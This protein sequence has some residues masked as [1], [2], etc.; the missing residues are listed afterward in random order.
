MCWRNQCFVLTAWQTFTDSEFSLHCL[1]GG[2]FYLFGKEN[3]AVIAREICK[4]LGF[5]PL[6]SSI[7]IISW[8]KIRHRFVT[9]SCCAWIDC[10]KRIP[11]MAAE[12][13][14]RIDGLSKRVARCS[15]VNVTAELLRDEGLLH[16]V[17][18]DYQVDGVNWLLQCHSNGHG[19]ILGDD[20]GLGKTLQVRCKFDVVYKL[21]LTALKPRPR[22]T[23][24]EEQM[25]SCADYNNYFLVQDIS[26]L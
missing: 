6:Q 18:R 5:E 8:I 23:Q 14:R 21:R 17:P 12:I 16:M 26:Q 10:A 25:R 19:C 24:P 7:W 3:E 20:M 4:A 2:H 11:A 1:P 22:S 15:S 13:W 9:W